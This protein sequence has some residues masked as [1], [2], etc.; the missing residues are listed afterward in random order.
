MAA[1]RNLKI[2]L[3]DDYKHVVTLEDASSNPWDLTGYTG[4]SHVRLNPKSIAAP[5]ASFT[6]TVTVPLSGILEMEMD[7]LVTAAL[8]PSKTYYYDLQ[9]TDSLGEKTTILEGTIDVEQDVTH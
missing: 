3:G 8:N 1:T 7:S 5:E 9:L 2:K 4:L 6:I